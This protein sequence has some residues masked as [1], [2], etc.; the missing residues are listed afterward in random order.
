MPVRR[1]VAVIYGLYN[2]MIKKIIAL[3]VVR[4]T[5]TI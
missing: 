4:I 2:A 3:I 1:D 5:I